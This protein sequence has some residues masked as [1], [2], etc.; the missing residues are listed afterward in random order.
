MLSD[1]LVGHF[2]LFVLL[3]LDE[4]QL[5][6]LVGVIVLELLVKHVQVLLQTVVL[7][8]DVDD[9]VLQFCL[10]SY[11]LFHLLL[12][13]P[14]LHPHLVPDLPHPLL[15][16]LYQLFHVVPSDGGAAVLFSP[17]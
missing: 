2:P 10:L 9:L 5:G 12:L 8:L 11:D 1:L 15:L 17:A 14:L 3:S 13:L 6:H 7:A 4:S 16:D